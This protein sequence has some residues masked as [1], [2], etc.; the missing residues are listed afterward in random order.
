[1]AESEALERLIEV[2]WGAYVEGRKAPLTRKAGVGYA[3]PYDGLS[4]DCLAR[5]D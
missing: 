4:L 2:A 5:G 1:V 3:D